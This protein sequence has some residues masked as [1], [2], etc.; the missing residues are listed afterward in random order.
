MLKKVLAASDRRFLILDHT[1]FGRKG[2]YRIAARGSF[3]A[4]FSD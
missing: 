4:I 3:D 1:K 2:I